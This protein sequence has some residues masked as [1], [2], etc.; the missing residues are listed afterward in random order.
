MK[1]LG[2]LLVAGL[3][4][5]LPVANFGG[6]ALA[7]TTNAS[8]APSTV[9]R[10]TTDHGFVANPKTVEHVQIALARAGSDV[11]IDGIWGPKTTQALKTF[12][13]AHHLKVSGYPDRATLKALDHVIE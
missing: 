5:A 3:I 13:L 11:A 6:T 9:T 4:V 12:Q 10:T 1:R 7:A 2:K 8:T